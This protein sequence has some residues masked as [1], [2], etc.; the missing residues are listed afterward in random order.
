MKIYFPSEHE[1]VPAS[2][3]PHPLNTAY[4]VSWGIEHWGSHAAPVLKVQ[5]VYEGQVSGR[6]SPSYPKG[7][8]D[9]DRVMAVMQKMLRA[10][11]GAA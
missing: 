1:D 5:M 3:P 2:S 7:T 4:R 11:N 9:A 10:M 8:D 6:R